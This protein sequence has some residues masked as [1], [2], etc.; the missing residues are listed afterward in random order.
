MP[1]FNHLGQAPA[2]D[3]AAWIAPTA[4][5]C[6]DVWIDPGS[7]VCHGAVL[8]AGDGMV[9]LGRECVV[10]ENAVL[11]AARRAPLRIGNNVLVGPRSYLTG[12]TI[13]DEA[14]LATGSTVFNLATVGRSAEVR[15]NGVVHIR[16]RLPPNATVP[17]GW[18]AVGDPAGLPTRG[19]R[20]RSPRFGRD[21]HAGADPSLR[22]STAPPRGGPMPAG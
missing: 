10:M 11:K 19:V 3:P 7:A 22:R 14:F 1:R 17:I 20:P 4:I 6:G 13:E 15:I 8:D 12:C 9:E 5:L 21:A 2:V 18:V 16:T